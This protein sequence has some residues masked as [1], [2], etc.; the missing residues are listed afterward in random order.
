[1]R[2]LLTIG[3]LLVLVSCTGSEFTVPLAPPTSLVPPPTVTPTRLLIPTPYPTHTLHPTATPIRATTSTPTPTQTPKPASL[4]VLAGRTQPLTDSIVQVRSEAVGSG[5]IINEYGDVLTNA[6]VVGKSGIVEV[7]LSHG[8]SMRGE[9]VLVDQEWEIALIRL[10]NPEEERLDP[11]P[12][13]ESIGIEWGPDVIIFER[14]PGATD[15]IEINGDVVD[16]V[17]ALDGAEWMRVRTPI[18]PGTSG[19]PLYGGR[20]VGRHGKALGIVVP[21]EPRG[22][23]N[24]G[25][26]YVLTA[27]A[28]KGR[29]NRLGSRGGDAPAKTPVPG[30]NT[31]GT[32]AWSYW[33]Y[34]CKPEYANCLPP[35]D[36]TLS[37]SI[38]LDATAFAPHSDKIGDPPS[39]E[40]ECSSD[41][42]VLADFHINGLAL[43]QRDRLGIGTWTAGE[44]D[45]RVRNSG[46]GYGRSGYGYRRS[47]SGYPTSTVYFNY[48][49]A[50]D[51]VRL[52]HEAESAGETIQFGTESKR[53]TAVGV[54]DSTGFSTNYWRLPCTQ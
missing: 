53:G 38:T 40:I 33:S 35:D 18:S 9:V 54:F 1:M 46:Y 25:Y 13:G 5:F 19:G 28:I 27:E 22:W 43:Q 2:L 12:L 6:H 11:L 32:G 24:E 26:T 47:G 36:S 29:L 31:V 16:R 21:K 45:K 20:L 17:Y 8:Q 3:L 7:Q 4:T 41:G 23:E 50:M 49:D 42:K 14:P 10:H 44:I 15:T 51:V 48:A 34:N 30:A 39:L 52:F 37:E